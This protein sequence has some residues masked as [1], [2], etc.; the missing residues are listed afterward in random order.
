MRTCENIT[1][2][3]MSNM[4]PSAGDF[5]AHS[6]SSSAT[7]IPEYTGESGHEPA[8][9]RACARACAYLCWVVL[10]CAP[11]GSA[12]FPAEM[13]SG[14]QRRSSAAAESSCSGSS[15]H[16]R[17]PLGWTLGDVFLLFF[18]FSLSVIATKNK[19]PFPAAAAHARPCV[20]ILRLFQVDV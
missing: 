15:A 17:R 3:L 19:R 16:P 20:D 2:F 10:I 1:G 7:N 4:K 8:N 11:D 5:T 12:S 9:G 6:N 14:P 13:A 18:S